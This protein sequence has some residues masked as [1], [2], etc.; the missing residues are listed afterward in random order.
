M[1][2]GHRYGFHDDSFQVW[3]K[4]LPTKIFSSFALT[5]QSRL[6]IANRSDW[7]IIDIDEKAYSHIV[8]LDPVS[9]LWT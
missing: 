3:K 7:Q 2:S 5:A 6:N 8:L 4:S 9:L 1:N